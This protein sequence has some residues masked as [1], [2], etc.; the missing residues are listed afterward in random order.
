MGKRKKVKKKVSGTGYA[1][2][3][4]TKYSRLRKYTGVLIVT[5]KMD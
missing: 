3:V 5:G 4:E 1:K 2:G